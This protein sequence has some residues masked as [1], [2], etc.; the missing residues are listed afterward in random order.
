MR[1]G[2]C[3]TSKK[4]GPATSNS[5]CSPVRM[6]ES[7]NQES[8]RRQPSPSGF[9]QR[10]LPERFNGEIPDFEGTARLPPGE[11]GDGEPPG[12]SFGT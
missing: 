3:R 12:H 11:A 1:S 5:V 7:N 8:R 10:S 6:P 9:P 2:S 4:S